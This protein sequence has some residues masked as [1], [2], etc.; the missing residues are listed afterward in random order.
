LF[1]FFVEETTALDPKAFCVEMGR[2]GPPP[3]AVKEITEQASMSNPQPNVVGRQL[4]VH[5]DIDLN[6]AS[7][8][9]LNEIPE[10]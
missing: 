2:Q 10:E 4:F 5:H 8:F 1:C 3:K 6:K 7:D 9:D